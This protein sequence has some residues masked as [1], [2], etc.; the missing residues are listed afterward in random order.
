MPSTSH[1]LPAHCLQKHV[2]IGLQ[3]EGSGVSGVLGDASRSL[4][5]GAPL[6]SCTPIHWARMAM[7]CPADLR[8]CT[9]QPF[10]A[11]MTGSYLQRDMGGCKRS[12]QATFHGHRIVQSGSISPK[13]G[14]TATAV[15]FPRIA[16]C[17]RL[18]SSRLGNGGESFSTLIY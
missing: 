12:A 9:V 4:G 11:A 14:L 3:V 15:L 7:V 13:L 10:T 2:V 5:P 8:T 17:S 16:G 18:G 1:G 6:G